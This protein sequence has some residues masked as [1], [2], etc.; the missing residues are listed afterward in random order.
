MGRETTE[1]PYRAIPA[2]ECIRVACQASDV[3][4]SKDSL[5]DVKVPVIVRGATHG[6]NV[7]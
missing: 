2:D 7:R 1:E 4:A 5:I 3:V 6:V